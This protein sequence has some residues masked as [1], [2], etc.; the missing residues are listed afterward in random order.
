MSNKIISL[1]MENI[2]KIKAIEIK[3]GDNNMVV[4]SGKNG[5]GKSSVLDAISWAFEGLAKVQARP[6]RLGQNKAWIR[7]D[8]GEY[9][10]ERTFKADEKGEITN[11][12]TVTSADGATY[13]SPQALLEKCFNALSFNPLKFSMAEKKEQVAMLESLVPGFDFVVSRLD[14]KTTYDERTV[15]NRKAE[16]SSLKHVSFKDIPVAEPPVVDV[17]AL[18][19]RLA[20]VSTKNEGLRVLQ[21][22]R[23]KNLAVI[24]E[25]KALNRKHELEGQAEMVAATLALDTAKKAFDLAE[26]SHKEAVLKFEK[27]RDYV[28]KN[29]LEL[30][31]AEL[32]IVGLPPLA[33]LENVDSIKSELDAATTL[34]DIHD[35]WTQKNEAKKSI[36]EHKKNSEILTNKIAEIQ[37]ARFNAVAQSGLPVKGLTFDSEGVLLN[38][39]PFEQASSAEQLRVSVGIAMVQN[40]DLKVIRIQDGSL[41]DSDGMALISQMADQN[42]IQCWIERVG[43]GEVG[44]ELV[45]GELKQ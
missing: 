3:P 4:V 44:F 23:Q 20:N 26:N 32:E 45:D 39:L 43:T 22:E 34:N 17:K 25:H 24:E 27:A 15:E 30:K 1:Q 7:I 28:Y 5:S 14:E 41:L 40:P 31:S 33:E 2:K 16:E 9:I 19:E 21:N 10:I 42:D 36:D 6:I 29:G 35:K 13:K 12:L 37:K 38:G 11:K 8:L 18:T